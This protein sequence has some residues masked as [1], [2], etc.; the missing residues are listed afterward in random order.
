MEDGWFMG[1]FLRI[2]INI[3]AMIM[4]SI[5]IFV[6]LKR[7]DR[8]E[9]LNRKFL[10]TAFII[11]AEVFFE[12]ATCIINKRPEHWLIPVTIF[13]HTCLYA[14]AP[15]LTYY[16]YTFIHSWIMPENVISR[17]KNEVL[18]IPVIIN[19]AITLLSPSY[20]L[21]FYISSSNVY[22]RGK[23]F[24]IS[25]LIVYFYILMSSLLILKNRKNIVR[26]DFVP[27][28]IYGILPGLGGIIQASFYGVL[29]MWSSTAFS[30]VIV[31]IFLQQRMIHLDSLTGV[32]TRESFN[33]FIYQKSRKGISEKFGAVY[34]DL[35]NL[36]QINDKYGHLEGDNA[37]RTSVQIIRSA[38]DKN[39]VIARLGGDEFIIIKNCNS[40]DILDKLIL[41]IEKS[42]R[43][44][45][46]R[47][48]M[49]YNLE[50]S[51][52]A[53]IYDDNY[54]NI[55]HFMK[56]IDYIMYCNKRSKKS[57]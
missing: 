41:D 2:D 29:L 49:Q 23:L 16:W 1:V 32:W 8:K 55:E 40:K 56:N 46:E 5:V 28:F 44:H 37:I 42:F 53:D 35:D 34:I 31:Y 43:L 3:A 36:K 10:I 52:G 57:R 12:T 18:L 14:T 19:A 17:R 9:R 4:L 7:L 22:H 33:T 11:V 51:C 54:S 48:N 39:D 6:A 30:M 25:L 26:D 24:Y 27:L 15:V 20:K 47:S 45:N 50:C 21:V 13:F 38:L